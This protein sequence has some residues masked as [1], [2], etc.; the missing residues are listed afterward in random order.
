NSTKVYD[1]LLSN[2][3]ESSR[4]R[5]KDEALCYGLP[6]GTFGTIDWFITI[7]EIALTY[8]NLS[9]YSPWKWG[10]K[11]GKKYERPKL[12]SLL[13][14]SI[15]VIGPVIYSIVTCH[16]N[17]TMVLIAIG[18]LIPWSIKI[19][20][21]GYASKVGDDLEKNYRTYGLVLT[22]ILHMIGWVGLGAI[23]FDPYKN[24][25]QIAFM[26]MF[27]TAYLICYH[28][29]C[30]KYMCKCLHPYP[31]CLMV[32]FY[33]LVTTHVLTL[34]ICLAKLNNNMNGV[35]PKIPKLIKLGRAK[36]EIVAKIKYW[37]KFEEYPETSEDRVVYVYNIVGID[38]KKAF[39]IFNLK[40]IQ[41]AYKDETTHESIYCSF[42]KTKVYKETRTCCG[43][44]MCQVVVSE[45][46]AIKHVL[47]NFNNNLFK[48]YLKQVNCLYI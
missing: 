15:K 9:L 30:W 25:I 1:D 39:E 41:Y 28:M 43:V 46:V 13:F 47:V 21:D 17:W 22:V 10:K 23:L 4:L 18:Q 14:S 12:K 24:A 8:A 37:L 11:W 35:P 33:I 7:V 26:M 40:N 5:F 32:L 16:S 31:C 34:H 29:C 19:A 36:R 38:T 44:K 20:N 2:L 6:Y 3:T 45:L 27:T 48:K 42:L